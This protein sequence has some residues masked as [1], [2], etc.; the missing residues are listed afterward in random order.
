MI[1]EASCLQTR[2]VIGQ[3]MAIAFQS[4]FVPFVLSYTKQSLRLDFLWADVCMAGAV[5]FDFRVESKSR[6]IIVTGEVGGITFL[7]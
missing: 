5:D 1:A 2:K 6:R 3:L 7:P 4:F